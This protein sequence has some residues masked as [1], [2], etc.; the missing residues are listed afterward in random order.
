MAS[1][2]PA[3]VTDVQSGRRR[4]AGEPPSERTFLEG[5]FPFA[6]LSDLARAD[7]LLRDPVYSAHKWWARRPR[8]VIRALVLAAHLPASTTPSE[9]WAQFSEDR[10]LLDGAHV[11]DPFCGGGTTLLEG[12]RLGAA[13][14]GTDVDP[15]AVRIAIDQLAPTQKDLL[16]TASSE[17]LAHLQGEFECLYPAR[18]GTTPLHYFRLRSATCVSCERQSLVYRSPVLVRDLGRVGAVVRDGK[19][20]VVCPSCRHL[21][22]IGAKARTF[23][24]CGKR[25]RLDQG[26]FAR[27]GFT[28]PSC[29]EIATLEQLGAAGLIEEL[30]AVE[31]TREMLPREIS[32][33]CKEDLDALSR[34]RELRTNVG[35][36]LGQSLEGIDGGRPHSYGFELVDDLF[37][38][39]QALIFAEAFRWLAT[40]DL[41]ATVR[42]SLELA[43]SNAVSSNNRIC[44]YA[45]DY[46]RLA[47]AFTGVR[48]YSLPILAVELNPLHPSGGR[49]TLAATLR[50]LDRSRADTVRRKV[51]VA[52]ALAERGMVARRTVPFVVACR[53]AEQS[54]DDHRREE[55]SA[56]ITDPPYYDFIAYSDLSL[57]HRVWLGAN[58]EEGLGGKPIFPSGEKG[59]EDFIRGLGNAFAR[60]RE[61]LA[62]NAVLAF[63]YHSQHARAW[64]GLAVAVGRA[65]LMVTSAFPVWADAR[66]TVAHG[67]P[68]SCEWD[69]VWVCRR[70]QAAPW[71]ALPEGIEGWEE[72][73]G[74]LSGADQESLALGLAAARWVNSQ[75]GDEDNPSNSS[76]SLPS[77]A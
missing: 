5:A 25:H 17:L 60:A 37:G 59:H 57:L 64:E 18:A 61:N 47:P 16:S 46:G 15:L 49:G 56:V 52:G 2:A 71:I 19:Q 42:T 51:R 70:R 3:A 4:R 28:C 58:G 75:T 29:A 74:K 44:G 69:L 12:A 62:Q 53:S 72:R 45:T 77:P 63:T 10:P 48:S 30:V 6:E 22:H 65:G 38:D 13:V 41:D 7:K 21:H 54:P 32:A 11:G 35:R 68:G 20:V 50:R 27:A 40:A 73:A 9:F 43:V 55:F 24:C 8:G 36:T 76:M 1:L 66:S 67:H 26:S 39:R 14:S 31:L 23:V 33:P 34:A